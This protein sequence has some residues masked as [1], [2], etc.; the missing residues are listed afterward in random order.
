MWAADWNEVA[1]TD[2]SRICL[3]HHDGRIRVLRH[4][5]E[6]TT[7]LVLH[8]VLWVWPQSY[9]NRIIRDHTWFQ[10]LSKYCPKVL[11]YHQTELLPL[12]ARSPD[13]PPI[14]NM[15]SMVAQR[16]TQITPPAVTTNQLWQHIEAT[17]SSVPQEH[18]QSF[19]ESMP[20]RVTAVISSNG[21]YSGN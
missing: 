3:Q 5:G 7:T 15:W 1:F 9:F 4:H 12:S 17:W 8:S 10:R 21:G 14:E 16:L 6:R 20:K 13:L 2:E 19:F 18:N 11:R